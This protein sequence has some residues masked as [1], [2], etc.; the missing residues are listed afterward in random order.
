MSPSRRF[1]LGHDADGGL[2]D[3]MAA[4]HTRQHNWPFR[5]ARF[6]CT[7]PEYD[8]ICHD[9]LCGGNNKLM[10]WSPSSIHETAYLFAGLHGRTTS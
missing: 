3:M 6:T 9:W 8:N 5:H 4:V 1:V 10:P 7:S 2:M